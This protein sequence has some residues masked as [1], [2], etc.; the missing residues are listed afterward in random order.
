MTPQECCVLIPSLSPDERL[1]EIIE[2]KNHP[3]FI[4]VQFHP[5]SILTPDGKTMLQN[6]IKEM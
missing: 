6:F 5:E 2:L 3:W 4:G 1:V